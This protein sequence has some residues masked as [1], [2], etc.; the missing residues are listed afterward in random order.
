MHSSESQTSNDASGPNAC[1]IAVLT[2]MTS[3]MGSASQLLHHDVK[4]QLVVALHVD[5]AACF[6]ATTQSLCLVMVQ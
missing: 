3:F 4:A 2:T 6:S 1:T 5:E